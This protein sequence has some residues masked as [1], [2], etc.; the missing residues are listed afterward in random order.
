[1]KPS[2]VPDDGATTHGTAEDDSCA[3]PKLRLYSLNRHH[4]QHTA[5]NPPVPRSADGHR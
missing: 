4:R 5:P 3:C 2:A 1:M